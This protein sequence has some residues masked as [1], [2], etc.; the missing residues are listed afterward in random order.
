M[1][2]AY[3]EALPITAR[4]DDITTALRDHQVVVVAGETGSGKTTQL[5]KMA[6]ELGARSIAHT[7]P[8]RIAA[9]SVARRIADECDV[10]L[11]AEVGYAV[12]FDDTSRRDTAIRLVTDGL[13]LSEIH[14]DRDLRRYDTII[15]DEA[16]ERS[17]AIDFLLGYLKQL[18]PRRTDLKVVITSATIDVDRFAAMFDAPVIEV[19]GRTYPVEIR[20]RPLAESGDDWLDGISSALD[21]LPST[22]SADGAPGDVL[23]FLSGE[24]EIRDAAEHLEGRKLPRTEVLPLYGR[25][26]AHDQQKIFAPHSGRRIVLST[27][28]AETSLTVP[29]IRYVIDPG[30][31]RISRFSQRLKVQRLPIEPISQASAAQRAGR[32]GRVADGICI[33]LYSEEDHDGRPEY[34]DPEILRTNLAS[35]LLQMAALDLGSI[36]EFPF[37]DPPDSRAVSDGVQLLR[38]LGALSEKDRLTK[39]G[40][41][42][43]T[44]PVDPRLARMLLAADLLGCLADVLVVVAAM[45]I[46]DPRE[47]PL[48]KQQAADEKHARFRQPDSDFLSWLSLWTYLREQRSAM[49]HSAFRR[50]CRDEFLHYL[51]IREWHDVHSQLRRTAKDLG[52]R[53]GR[54]GAD[55]DLV[56]QALLTG[57]LSH[58][59]LRDADGRDYL[60]ARGAKFRIFPGSGVAKKP[61][62]WVMAGELV[63][64]TRLWG[65][66]VAR[67]QPEWIEKAAGHLVKRQ[68]AEP[69]WSARR[70]A[71]M[72]RERV[73]LYGVPIV[74]DRLVP[75]ARVDA[76]L[77]REL[78]I[79]HALVQGE[80]RTHHA[81]WA[82]NQELIGEVEDLEARLRRPDLMVDDD[83][84]F[85]F[86][87][88]RVPPEVVSTR[89][90][91]A[92]WK[93]ARRDQPD[94]L[95]VDPA[96]LLAD[97]VPD[98]EAEFP[99]TWRSESDA[100]H[101]TYAFEPGSAADGVTIDVPVTELL[102]FDPTPFQWNV[103]GRR[104][105][106]VTALIRT[107]PKN[108]RRQLV[109]AADHAA[110]L[111]EAM[112][113]DAPDLTAE[114]ARQVRRSTGTVVEPTAFDLSAVPEHLR[115]SFRVVDGDTELTRGRDVEAL[116]AELAPR[117]RAGLEEQ[118]ADLEHSG[119]TSWD[120]GTIER[121]ITVGQVTGYPALVDD[122]SSV[123]MRV[124]DSAVEQEVAMVRGQ[125][126]LLALSLPTVVPQIGRTLDVR[127]KLLLA[128]A[129]Y[130]DPAAVIEE[131]RIAALDQLV[132]DHGVAWDEAG[133]GALRD[134]VRADVHD[135]TVRA[136]NDVIAAMAKLAEVIPDDSPAGEDVRVQLSWLVHPDLVREM[137]TQRL[138]RLA[139][140]LEAARRRLQAPT[141]EPVLALYEL[142]ARFHDHAS[143]LRP[144]QRL[145]PAV[146]HVRWALEELRI[147]LFAQGLGTA[148]PVSVKRVTRLVDDLVGR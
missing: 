103:P 147:S 75:L 46:Q 101:V 34:T 48:E 58:I 38:E 79:R 130:A 70:G 52:M 73:T 2:I 36:T 112:D 77:A 139:L 116:R 62:R 59:G 143:R 92:W 21:E 107:L 26:A 105:E 56:H 40:R 14:H 121:T 20:Y 23:V 33:R 54:T 51:R 126:R 47:R 140:Y 104:L 63:E 76:S 128:T 83:A 65:R 133:F 27:N 43:S 80:W 78:F 108:L 124:L 106:L 19:S 146:Q 16:H 125:A 110:R 71:A 148:F 141:T 35:V 74:V 93:Q 68:H 37:L 144:W 132:A 17:L 3:D 49:S 87:D 11:G 44:L 98:V 131:C 29:G 115:V 120:V 15:V 135:L 12:R 4:R 30:L 86:Y 81:F 31:A 5:P 24:R 88:A 145:A 42:M 82:R 10:E 55:P 60:G 7:Q 13:L 6:Y 8:R 142:E 66:T 9:R 61:P 67:I 28:V 99:S 119:I 97:E 45:S 90:F 91:D 57:L 127:Q 122:G 109:P 94:L 138:P 22:G 39:L 85:S 137:G 95:T 123:S 136:V 96:M 18:L 114:L 84:L 64:T 1:R 100:Y 89:H 50:M 102:A 41:T 134:A 111:L 118:A 32:C 113:Q 25:L 53:P 72:A 117:L 69:H 129:P